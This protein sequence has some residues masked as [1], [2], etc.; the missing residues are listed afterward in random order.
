MRSHLSLRDWT[1]QLLPK[2]SRC[3][4]VAAT[5]LVGALMLA[6]TTNLSELA[7]QRDHTSARVSRQFFKRW[8][9]RPQWDPEEVYAGLNRFSRRILKGRR[10][11]LLLVD[12]TFLKNQWMVLNIS[13]PWRGRALPLYRAVVVWKG[14]PITQREMV[15]NACEW[16]RQNLPGP[17]GRYIL[18][19]DRGFPSHALLREWQRQG[20]RFVARIKGSWKM[21]HPSFTGRLYLAPRRPNQPVC[22]GDAV[23]GSRHRE[24]KSRV[25]HSST[26][27]V[28]F[29]GSG[30]AEPWY[31][32]TTERK[33]QVVVALYR[34]RMQ[35]EQEFRDLKG[36][37]GID[38]LAAWISV[39]AVARFLAWMAA[40]EW[41]LAY[42]WL[43][44]HLENYACQI[45]VKGRLSWIRVA[46][47]WISRRSRGANLRALACL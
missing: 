6:F 8:L 3:A 26:N 15:V 40:Y 4:H 34:Q 13:L 47:T 9:A 36:P 14:S 32:V 12:T 20:W 16:L 35:I 27:V 17:L 33:P 38:A 1:A 28:I 23:L 18:V 21:T 39:D 46:R 30:H 5:D 24:E 37:L 44:N 31:L 2:E 41:R 25:R 19:A 10:R 43:V 42:L 22:Y 45:R 11:V 29:D 7:R